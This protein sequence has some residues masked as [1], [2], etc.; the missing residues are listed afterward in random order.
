MLNRHVARAKQLAEL[1]PASREVLEYYTRVAAFSGD[2]HDLANIARHAPPPLRQAVR[3]LDGAKLQEATSAYLSGRDVKSGRSL[4]ARLMLRHTPL[5]ASASRSPHRCP[6]CGQ[7]PQCGVLDPE[8]DGNALSLVCS[9]CQH[10]WRARRGQ[11]PSCA[12]DDPEQVYVYHAEAIPQVETQ[13][14]DACT[15]Y[16]HLIRRDRDPQAIPEV[17]EL[18]ALPLDVMCMDYGFVK[19]HP[20]LAGV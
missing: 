11:C 6:Q 18:I 9:L 8:G 16:L 19:I 17:D 12:V 1:F 5:V 3:D 20:N 7:P 13:V 2:F 10:E 14:C 4:F 15:H